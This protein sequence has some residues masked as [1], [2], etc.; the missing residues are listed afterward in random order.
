MSTVSTEVHIRWMIRRDMPEVLAIEQLAFP[1]PWQEDDFIK[2]LKRRDCIGMVAEDSETGMV[3]GFMIYHLP[4]GKIRLENLAVHPDF[5]RMGIGRKMIEK[6]Q[7]KL[8]SKRRS[9]SMVVR[10]TNLPTQLFFR[11]CGCRA[12]NILRGYYDNTDED[13]YVF[14]CVT[15]AALPS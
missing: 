10:E 7:G 14:R 3:V 11:S 6:L 4:K 13:A 8:G 2:C 1:D 5:R 15:A 12:V 9:L